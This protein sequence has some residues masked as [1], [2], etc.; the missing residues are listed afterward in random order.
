MNARQLIEHTDAAKTIA[1]MKRVVDVWSNEDSDWVS[2]GCADVTYALWRIG[3]RLG[4][5]CSPVTGNAEM[6]DGDVF[7]HAWL[8]VAGRVFDPVGYA[9]NY[10]VHRYHPNGGGEAEHV[11]TLSDTFGVETD[12]SDYGFDADEAIRS[13]GL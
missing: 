2:D 11:K 4:W 1:T 8:N 6:K 12:E 7:Q 13:L 9:N 10:K 5:P 3:Q